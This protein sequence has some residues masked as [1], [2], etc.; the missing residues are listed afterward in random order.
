MLV[1]RL[2][3][4]AAAIYALD[5]G[6]A[7]LRAGTGQYLSRCAAPV[8]LALA[9]RA[10]RGAPGASGLPT[11]AG[12]VLAI[13]RAVLQLRD[14]FPAACPACSGSGRILGWV[15]LV[16][17]RRRPLSP[18]V[19][20]AL[21]D[22]AQVLGG[23]LAPASPMAG[24]RP[25]PAADPDR[26]AGSERADEQATQTWIAEML[27]RRSEASTSAFLLIDL[28][29]FH[30][31]NE[32]L[33]SATGDQVLDRTRSRI[34]DVLG[35]G[36]C[37]LRLAGDRFG[38]VAERAGSDPRSLADRLLSTSAWEGGPAALLSG[39]SQHARDNTFATQLLHRLRDGSLSAGAA[40]AWL[41]R[42][43]EAS[44]SDAEQI[45]IREHQTLAAGNVTTGNIIRGLRVAN[46][47]D[48]TVWFEKVSRVDRLFRERTDFA[49]LDFQSRDQYRTA[50][51]DLA[52]RSKKNEYDVAL[53][54]IEMAEADADATTT[55]G[56]DVGSLL[57]GAR[58]SEVEKD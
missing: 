31:L 37:L 20:T 30:A 45:I 16:D 13:D 36:E 4:R 27:A 32:V 41:E 15:V 2:P 21:R 18:A 49:R 57:V 54:V 29:R 34:R 10:I 40:L 52:R 8:G 43:L 11:A 42:E 26:H 33:G 5:G 14:G 6:S 44:G 38:I 46:D 7:R 56:P 12:E 55:D 39:F 22:C 51:E 25:A 53:R 48:W 50:V 9:D 1:R 3:G 17:A 58:R 23:I 24:D 19:V 35:P 28:D 47:L